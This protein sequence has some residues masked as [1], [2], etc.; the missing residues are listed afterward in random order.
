[1]SCMKKL[2]FEGAAVAIVTPFNPDGSINLDKYRELIDYQIENGTDC[3]V[4]VGTTGENATLSGEEHRALMR[5]CVEHVNGRVPVICSTGSNDTAYGCETT[6]AAQEAGADG[7]LLVTPYYNKTSQRGLIRHYEKLLSDVSI[8]AIIYN[9]PSRTGMNISIETYKEL[10]KNPQIVGVKEASGNISQVASIISE[11]GDDMP[12]YSGNDDQIVPLM[13]L[14][15]KGVISVMS[16]V[17]PRE[18]HDICRYC[19]NEDYKSARELAIRYLDIANKLFVDV[20]PVPVKAAMN[21][22]G[23]DVGGCRLPLG[24]LTP[25]HEK[26]LKE[27]LLKIGLIK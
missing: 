2:I 15:G 24:D 9:V 27:A 25:E 20:N 22:M 6:K 26:V 11:C 21:M 4:A 5:C 12:V 17:L 19:L 13:S 3:I 16:N 8:P 7:L 23:F 18:T 14:G 1:M 10:A